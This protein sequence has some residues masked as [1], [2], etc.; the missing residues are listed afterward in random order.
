M[1]EE[2]EETAVAT[3]CIEVVNGLKLNRLAGGKSVLYVGVHTHAVGRPLVSLVISKDACN[4]SMYIDDEC[5]FTLDGHDIGNARL[6]KIARAAF[7]KYFGEALRTSLPNKAALK[8]ENDALKAG[9]PLPGEE[10]KDSLN[11]R[12]DAWFAK[13]G[14]G[15][16]TAEDR[17]EFNRLVAEYTKHDRTIW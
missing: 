6:E 10:D 4:A 17:M 14:D 15:P 12:C 3:G 5:K 1:K 2:E 8:A 13:V 9:L 11:A 7:L 16:I